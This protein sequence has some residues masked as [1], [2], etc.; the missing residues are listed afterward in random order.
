ML[1]NLVDGR[2][3]YRY[4]TFI[5]YA[6]YWIIFDPIIFQDLEFGYEQADQATAWI[7]LLPRY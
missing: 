3:L 6:S 1:E 5:S 7:R 2:M 4:Y